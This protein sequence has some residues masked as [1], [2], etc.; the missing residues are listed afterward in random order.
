MI[1]GNNKEFYGDVLRIVYDKEEASESYSY[2]ADLVE[3]GKVTDASKIARIIISPL[4][5][6]SL[7]A[8][9]KS[10]LQ[11]MVPKLLGQIDA[12]AKTKMWANLSQRE[13]AYLVAEK[14]V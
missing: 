13:Q 4:A 14:W 9:T 7:D 2:F 11:S 8:N 1:A 6:A 10:R 5:A 12:S 3:A